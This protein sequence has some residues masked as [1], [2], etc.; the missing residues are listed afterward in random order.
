MINQGEPMENAPELLPKPPSAPKPLET[1]PLPVP[2]MEPKPVQN[3]HLYDVSAS[4]NDIVAHLEASGGEMTEKNLEL[5]NGIQGE[6]GEKLDGCAMHL[7]ELSS[8]HSAIKSAGKRLADRAKAAGKDVERFKGYIQHHM[9]NMGMRENIGT[10]ATLRVQDNNA[11]CE[12]IDET[13]VPV[14]LTT[15]SVT[16]SGEAWNNLQPVLAE[17]IPEDSEEFGGEW[18]IDRTVDKKAVI[19]RWKESH[20][21][22]QTAGTIVSKGQ[23]LRL[24]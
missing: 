11:A 19:K 23:S 12:V 16:M 17:I 8:R 1:G 14:E 4:F 5:W 7:E 9:T 24:Y 15:V 21:S 20:E 22:V 3:A 13:K 2:E 18:K 6:A 10:V